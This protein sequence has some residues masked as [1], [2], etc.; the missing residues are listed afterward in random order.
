VG[1]LVSYRVG[2]EDAEFLEKQ[3]Q[4]IFSAKDLSNVDNYNFFAKLLLNNIATNPFNV[5]AYPPTDGSVELVP[6]LKELSRLKYGRDR[7]IVEQ[8]VMER[9]KIKNPVKS[10]FTRP[11]EGSESFFK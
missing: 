10:A 9:V 1:S 4:P 11:P 3:F 8:E 7:N 2:P 5:K 6:Y